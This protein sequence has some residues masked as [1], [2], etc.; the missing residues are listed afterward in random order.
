MDANIRAIGWCRGEAERIKELRRPRGRKGP[1]AFVILP[2][3]FSLTEKNERGLDKGKKKNPNPAC[4][5]IGGSKKEKEE[6]EFKWKKDTLAY[7]M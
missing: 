4:L 5:C 1:V 7:R 2:A 6:T 3:G